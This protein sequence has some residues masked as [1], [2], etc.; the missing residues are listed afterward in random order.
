MHSA[1]CHDFSN[2]AFAKKKLTKETLDYL[3]KMGYPEKALTNFQRTSCSLS[4]L[5]LLLSDSE[6]SPPQNLLM[7]GLSRGQGHQRP[8]DWP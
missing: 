2:R 4:L 3:K 8:S 7:A 5:E 1:N 6:S